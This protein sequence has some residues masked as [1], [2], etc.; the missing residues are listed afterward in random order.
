[1]TFSVSAL[2]KAISSS[3]SS[4]CSFSFDLIIF[5]VVLFIINRVRCCVVVDDSV[6]RTFC[7][8]LGYI[9]QSGTISPAGPFIG[10][11]EIGP[12]EKNKKKYLPFLAPALPPPAVC[13]GG[14]N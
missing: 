12:G 13:M 8:K 1:L 3:L 5:I 14:Q 6:I 9:G 11:V 4:V 10:P 7:E 2:L